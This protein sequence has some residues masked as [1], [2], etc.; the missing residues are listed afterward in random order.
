MQKLTAETNEPTEL[1]GG[2]KTASQVAASNRL[3]VLAAEIINAHAEARRAAQMSVEH[4]IRAVD[5]LIEAKGIMKHGEW[6]PWLRDNSQMSVIPL[7]A[8]IR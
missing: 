6:W 7:K 8:D 1:T 2:S 5:A 3:P 4:A